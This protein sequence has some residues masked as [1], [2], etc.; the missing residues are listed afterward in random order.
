MR[1][2]VLALMA[3]ALTQPVWAADPQPEDRGTSRQ[4]QVHPGD[5]PRQLPPGVR[6][7]DRDVQQQSQNPD[8]TQPQPG[9]SGAGET[10]AS[11]TGA[12]SATTGTP[13]S[14]QPSR[15]QVGDQPTQR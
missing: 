14:G 8:R 3:T 6:D 4:S 2:V 15:P 11:G 7:E 1:A 5:T 13:P 9:A 12:S 10:G